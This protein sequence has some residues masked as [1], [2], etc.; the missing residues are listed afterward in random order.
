MSIYPA[1]T[2]YLPGSPLNPGRDAQLDLAQ[3]PTPSSRDSILKLPLDK[4][5]LPKPGTTPLAASPQCAANKEMVTPA[6]APII[7]S[8]PRTSKTDSYDLVWRP[9]PDS[10]API[11]YYVVKHRKVSLLCPAPIFPLRPSMGGL[12]ASPRAAA[13]AP[14]PPW[15]HWLV[16][17]P[18]LQPQL[19]EV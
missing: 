8:S 16:G 12:V 3:P 17:P 14:V 6:E 13:G 1:V 7:L 18:E 2:P 19:G 4:A 10:R 9:R 5:G 15:W 11:L